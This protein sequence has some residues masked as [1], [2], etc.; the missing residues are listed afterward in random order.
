MSTSDDPVREVVDW[1]A[2][3]APFDDGAARHLQGSRV[4][5]VVLPATDGTSVTLASLPGR[6]VVYGYPRTGQP[7]EAPLVDG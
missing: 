5:D 3:P 1:S 6:T 7:G 4:P 2:V